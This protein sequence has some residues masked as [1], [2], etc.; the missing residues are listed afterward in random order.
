MGKTS[1]AVTKT[2]C[3]V[4]EARAVQRRAEGCAGD[5]PEN[6]CHLLNSGAVAKKDTTVGLAGLWSEKNKKA[7]ISRGLGN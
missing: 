2:A 6:M 4:N 3:R 7:A 1:A 5:S